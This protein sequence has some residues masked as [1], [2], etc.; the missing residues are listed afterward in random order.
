MSHIE[1]YLLV[2]TDDMKVLLNVNLFRKYD[3][4][5]HMYNIYRTYGKTIYP[6]PHDCLNIYMYL[7]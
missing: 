2:N 5:T 1:A 6:V 4:R 3:T 7:G